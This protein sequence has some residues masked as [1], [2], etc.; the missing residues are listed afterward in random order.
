MRFAFLVSAALL[1]STASFFAYASNE[2]APSVLT[3]PEDEMSSGS[4]INTINTVENSAE[5]ASH[6]DRSPAVLPGVVVV[7]PENAERAELPVA[8]VQPQ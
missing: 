6:V 2:A 4:V 7:D 1:S 5:A 3:A 8:E